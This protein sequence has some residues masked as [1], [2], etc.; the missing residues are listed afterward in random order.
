MNNATCL[1]NN[2]RIIL[3]GGK[4]W[5]GGKSYRLICFRGKLAQV[6]K[7]KR[8]GTRDTI[9]PT[10]QD[11]ACHF[12]IPVYYDDAAKRFFIRK[13]SGCR[14]KHNHH[15]PVNRDHMSLG[16][17]TV[18]SESLKQ[19]EKMLEKNAP[20]SVVDLMLKVRHSYYPHIRIYVYTGFF[21]RT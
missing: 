7:G 4:T 5:K 12:Y 2:Y 18:P 15:P 19:A 6:S 14:F 3:N 8:K 16:K 11:E 10:K 17:S 20:A 13:N 9:L 21:L 1:P